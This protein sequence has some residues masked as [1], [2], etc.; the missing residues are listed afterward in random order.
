MDK[1]LTFG[2]YN[3]NYDQAKRILEERIQKQKEII[4][5][6]EDKKKKD[7]DAI[8][9]AKQE[10]EDLE[11]EL[12]ELRNK[13]I[14]AMGSRTDFLSAATDFVDTWLDA[15]RDTG[16]GVDALRDHWK[17]FLDTLVV[18]QA[19]AALVSKRLEKVI[20]KIND[21]IDR[22]LTGTQLSSVIKSATDEWNSGAGE[23]NEAL[24]QFFEAMGIDLGN[25]ELGLSDLQKGIQNITE[26]QAA[27]IEA[28][29]NSMRYAVFRHTEQL[30]TL[31]A[32]VQAQYAV[33][34]DNP[35][36][37]ELKGIRSVLDSIDM[38]LGSVIGRKGIE[39]VVKVG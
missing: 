16:S 24:K 17:E 1:A 34:V 25:A 30:D 9:D 23:L 7:K 33:G 21:A 5:L 31:I 4:A 26:P 38:R 32:A 22:G 15:F 35:V 20:G 18:K 6:E 19:A 37:M 39:S 11:E 28:Y 3:A 8:R 2:L 13:R 27:A 36:V 29:L 12:T 14:E 10:I